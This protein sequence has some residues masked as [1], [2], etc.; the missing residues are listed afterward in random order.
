MSTTKTGSEGKCKWKS[1]T[2]MRRLH[3]FW[4]ITSGMGG[5][6]ADS[7]WMLHFSAGDRLK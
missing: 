2:A 7:P 1:M 4:E 6:S 3:D 5:L